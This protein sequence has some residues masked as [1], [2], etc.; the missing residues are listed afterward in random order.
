ML[1]GINS[2][3]KEAKMK[4]ITGFTL[5]ELLITVAIV[6]ILSSVAWPSYKYIVE[7]SRREDAKAGLMQLAQAMENHYSVNFTYSSSAQGAI[8][9]A[10]ASSV[11]PHSQT[12]FEGGSKYYN[13]KITSLAAQTWTIAAVPISTSAQ[14]G[15]RCGTLTLKNSGEKG[16][17]TGVSNCW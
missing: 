17:A 4:K 13:I 5:I 11:F 16:A 10:P 12:P 7:Q 8:P 9:S 14:S 15:D 6:G 3:T 2:K 1:I